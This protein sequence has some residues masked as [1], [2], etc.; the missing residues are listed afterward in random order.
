MVVAQLVLR[1]LPTDIH[2]HNLCLTANKLVK[3]A[4]FKLTDDKR[5]IKF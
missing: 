1:T 5:D 2:N 4:I 3:E